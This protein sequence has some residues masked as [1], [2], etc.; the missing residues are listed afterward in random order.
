MS[1]SYLFPIAGELGAFERARVRGVRPTFDRAAPDAPLRLE[2]GERVVLIAPGEDVTLHAVAPPVRA[3]GPALAA[4]RYAI[5]D[6]LAASLDDVEVVLGPRGPGREREAAVVACDRLQG[7]R[8]ALAALGVEAEH[9]VPDYAALPVEPETL[10]LVDLGDR[11]LARGPGV[12]FAVEAALAPAVIAAMLAGRPGLGVRLRSDRADALLG[13]A[14]RAGRAVA[15]E[16]AAEPGE[17]IALIHDT[18]R[19]GPGI[20]LA[21]AWRRRAGGGLALKDWRLAAGLAAAAL[22]SFIAL[23]GVETLTLKSGAAAAEDDAAQILREAF[24]DVGAGPNARAALRA[25]LGGG[26]GAASFLELSALLSES[27]AEVAA[28]EVESLRYDEADGRLAASISYAAYDDVQALKAAVDARGG[29]LTE[30]SARLVGGRMA[31][32]I[33]VSRP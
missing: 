17:I 24:P 19:T 33:E 27:L 32:D 23:I 22:L 21:R 8:N 10:L 12:G 31:G 18:L 11:V 13:E 30:G 6:D 16:P 3:E 29:R 4:A 5:E 9:V 28:V 25:E 2:A 14:A 15:L 1:V 20:D 26:R 7:W